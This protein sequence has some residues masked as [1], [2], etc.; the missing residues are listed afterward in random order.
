MQGL[1]SNFNLMALMW[2]SCDSYACIKCKALVFN[3][4]SG[5]TSYFACV[6]VRCPGGGGIESAEFLGSLCPSLDQECLPKGPCVRGSFCFPSQVSR[7]G[8]KTQRKPS[9]DI[10]IFGNSCI[11]GKSILGGGKNMT[12]FQ[13]LPKFIYWWSFLTLHINPLKS[14]ISQSKI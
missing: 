14:R 13:R 6:L 7:E 12:E 1:P 10:D 4:Q 5:D 3:K 9:N 11:R 8:G 2:L